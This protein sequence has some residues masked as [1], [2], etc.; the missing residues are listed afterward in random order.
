M[1]TSM[2]PSAKS[3]LDDLPTI[4]AILARVLGWNG[5]R[6][7][8]KYFPKVLNPCT[9][10]SPR[11]VRNRF[12][13]V[14]IP[15]HVFHLQVLI[16]HEVVRHHYAPCRLYSKVFTL[17]TYLEVFTCQFISKL[18]SIVGTKL[19]LRQ[20][21]LQ[22]F[23]RLLAFTE[24]SWVDNRI[25]VRIGVEVVQAYINS[26]SPKSWFPFFQAFVI[27]AKLYVVPICSTDN[28][29]SFKLFQLVFVQI[30]SPPPE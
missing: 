27:N 26:N 23:Q 16:R 20:T 1:V 29:H 25:A 28:P 12:G 22:S 17:A 5:N 13:E 30:A 18:G 21:T 11:C 24:M 19:S 4:G 14:S 15:H 6:N 9:E 8:A 3:L 10:L 2:S 7:H